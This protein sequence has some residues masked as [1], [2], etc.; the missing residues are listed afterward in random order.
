MKGKIDT[1]A[2][3]VKSMNEDDDDSDDGNSNTCTLESMDG[4]SD[5]DDWDVIGC[6]RRD[7][8]KTRN[9]NPR[10]NPNPRCKTAV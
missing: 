2:E 6:R 1:I 5:D 9:L 3:T 7:E 10:W 8:W 4:D